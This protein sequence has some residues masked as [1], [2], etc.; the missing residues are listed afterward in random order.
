[1]YLIL[2]NAHI[3]LAGLSIGGFLL[4]GVLHARESSMLQNRT[5][6][7]LPHVNDTLFLATGI[8]L[9]VI[10][11]LDVPQHEWLLAKFAGLILYI[12]LGLIAFR[13]GRTRLIRTAA[14]SGAV[15]SFIY[16]VG[17]ALMKSPL[18]WYA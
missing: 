3:V 5:A 11:N 17:A 2:K 9:A 4:R 6:K 12:G 8:W 14:F 13:F 7:V 10:L 18:S 1:M 16:I 15:L